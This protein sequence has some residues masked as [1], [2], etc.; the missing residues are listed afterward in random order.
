LK[1]III[2]GS[3]II[4]AS[5]AYNLSNED[6]DVTI[7]DA[8]L[9]GRATSAAAGIICPWVT[10]RRNKAWYTLAKNGAAYYNTLIN[11][12]ATDRFNE[13]GYKKVGAIRLHEDTA[14]LE[15]L[16][17]I[18]IHRRKSAPE[19]GHVQLLQQQEVQNK[20]PYIDEKYKGLFI[21]GA[22]RVDGR[23]LRDSMLQAAIQNGVKMMEGKATLKYKNDSSTYVSVNNQVLE[24]DQ[25]IV[26][27]GVW[28]NEIFK[29]L[30]ID[31]N[32]QAQKGEL[33]HLQI[34]N[35]N[36][37]SFPVIMPP[38]NQYMLS[39]AQ[40]RIV[41]GASHHHV[42]ELDTTITTD[43]MHY[44]LDQA[45]KMAPSLINSSIIETRVGFRPFTFNH[46]PV[47]GPIPGHEHILI[48][49]GLGASGLTTGPYIGKLLASL[50]VNEPIDIPLEAYHVAQ[51][52]N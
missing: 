8:S 45:L 34:A 50:S 12:L 10:K 4:G 11:R 42:K 22:A 32:I 25:I 41:I 13:T 51:I 37:D 33:I 23:L 30:Q 9:P 14:K 19:I 7:I 16:L 27:N 44:V 15:E 28:M 38:N 26:A 2:I 47:F 40:G 48:A 17:E 21:E 18:S 6:V 46:L 36:T 49:N 52:M 3:G 39:F 29:P 31:L 1:K 20:F 43:G 24:A 5:C 35:K